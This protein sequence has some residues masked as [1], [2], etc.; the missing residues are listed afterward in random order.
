VSLLLSSRALPGTQV[1][2]AQV[3]HEAELDAYLRELVRK[4][5]DLRRLSTQG[6]A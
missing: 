6:A 2:H 1:G 4:Q 5:T 3:I